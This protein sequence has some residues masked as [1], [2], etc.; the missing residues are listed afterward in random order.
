MTKSWLRTSKML[1]IEKQLLKI[2]NFS[3]HFKDA[4]VYMCMG[5]YAPAL[6]SHI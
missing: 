3:G 2:S 4:R 6:V 5:R 1:K